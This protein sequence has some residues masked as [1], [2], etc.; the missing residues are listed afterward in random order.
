MMNRY[1]IALNRVNIAQEELTTHAEENKENKLTIYEVAK[2]MDKVRKYPENKIE[3][4]EL[5]TCGFSI[6]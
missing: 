4:E 1:V 3:R 5:F 2:L 6:N